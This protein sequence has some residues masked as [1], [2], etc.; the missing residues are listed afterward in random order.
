VNKN[1]LVDAVASAA[2]LKKSDATTAVDAVF[3]SITA[4]LKN[5]AVVR[6]NRLK[7]AINVASVLGLSKAL[8]KTSYLFLL[9]RIKINNI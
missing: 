4:S 3:D 7:I 2:N 9:A 8:A 1:E 6:G 5:G